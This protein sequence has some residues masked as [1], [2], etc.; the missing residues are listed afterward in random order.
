MPPRAISPRSGSG[1]PRRREAIPI[2]VAA[3]MH[4]AVGA[5]RLVGV[6]QHDA[7]DRPR[8]G[9]EPGQD[10]AGSA[11]AT[12]S[13]V[14]RVRADPSP[15]GRPARLAASSGSSSPARLR[16]V[17]RAAGSGGQA[18]RGAAAVLLQMAGDQGLDGGTVVGVEV[19]AADQVLGQRPL[20]VERPG[21][22]GGDELP[23]VDQAVLEGEQAEEQVAVGGHGALR[24]LP[25]A[26][27]LAPRWRS[28]VRLF[29]CAP[30]HFVCVT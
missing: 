8:L 16:C 7:R 4:R 2:A 28:P 23:L 11:A 6:G 21:L 14:D 19:A 20:L 1:R 10:A 18:L 15:P 25:V 30:P 24:R 12:G 3:P 27:P 22:K 9:G 5:V 26:S 13:E 29:A 17:E